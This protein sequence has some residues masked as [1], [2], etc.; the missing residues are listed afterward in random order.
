MKNPAS[1]LRASLDA[2]RHD[3]SME[4]ARR[5]LGT[6]DALTAAA[7]AHAHR[8]LQGEEAQALFHDARTLGLFDAA[9]DSLTAAHLARAA[10]EA[11]LCHVRD[12]SE[13]AATRTWVFENREVPAAAVLDAMLFQPRARETTARFLEQKCDAFVSRVEDARSEANDAARPWLSSAAARPDAGP[14]P[15]ALAE[16]AREFL[17]GSRDPAF[18]LLER[19]ATQAGVSLPQTWDDLLRLLRCARFDSFAPRRE[20][21]RRVGSLFAPLEL[22]REL[23]RAVRVVGAHAELDIRA[24]V[25]PVHP[26]SDVRIAFSSIEFGVVSEMAAMESVARSLA[27]CLANSSLSVEAR[28]PLDATVARSIGFLF[29][30]LC[31]DN[32]FWRKSRGLGRTDADALASFGALVV[33]LD[34][35]LSAAAILARRVDARSG[36]ERRAQQREYVKD[37]L[38]GVRVT[39][40]MASLLVQTPAA[41]PARFRA[42][43]AALSVHIALRDRFDEDWFQNQRV[44][45]TLRSLT[46]ESGRVSIEEACGR[47][48]LSWSSAVERAS[49]IAI[50]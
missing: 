17:L 29:A 16:E 6:P 13:A 7:V 48:N 38:G 34:A 5:W 44:T 4:R 22:E 25:L 10:T 31:G 20:R 41:W 1:T 12:A 2:W 40:A 42:R 3:E 14:A 46:A 45:E 36:E 19:T 33:L 39:P 15:D 18:E 23:Q 8:R 26:P 47:E 49:E 11:V 37:A 27:L 24:R 30:Q 43:R 9:A 21:F 28:R 35:R 50:V 32:V